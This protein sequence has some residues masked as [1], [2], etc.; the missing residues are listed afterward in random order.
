MSLSHEVRGSLARCLATENIIV[1]HKDVDTAMFDVD[2]RILTL[3]NWKKA[4]DVVYQMLILHETSHAIFSHNLDYTKDYENLI[5]YHDV[6][7]VVEDA[8]V[9]KLM[10]KKYPGASR[11]FYT[12]YNE[13]NADD[14]FSTKDENLNELSLIDRINLYFK[15]GAFHQIVFN[16]VE[17]EFI[18]RICSAETFTDVLE[19]SQDLVAYAKKK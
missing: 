12:A 9:E 13:L 1:E 15:I 5:G 11:T 14:F 3:P 4:S 7:N 8:R 17:D 10:K 6:V 19:I 16:D 18:S 2:K